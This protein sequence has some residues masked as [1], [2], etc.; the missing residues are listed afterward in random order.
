MCLDLIFSIFKRGNSEKGD[1]RQATQN[2]LK[3]IETKTIYL[4][5]YY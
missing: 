1:K 3:S 5:T 2:S 4:F